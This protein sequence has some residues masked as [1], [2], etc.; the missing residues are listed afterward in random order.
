MVLFCLARL[1]CE[2]FYSFLVQF[3][4][5]AFYISLC[6]HLKMCLVCMSFCKPGSPVRQTSIA[7][8]ETETGVLLTYFMAI[9]TTI[10]RAYEAANESHPCS[11][12][13]CRNIRTSVA[14][15]SSW[16]FGER[17]LARLCCV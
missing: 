11:K 4:N 16:Y 7:G 6:K 8:W 1:G 14:L 17:Y 15:K 3:H 9:E 2:S 10:P 12:A 13:I 5:F